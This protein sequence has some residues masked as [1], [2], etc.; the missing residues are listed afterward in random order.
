MKALILL[1]I[2]TFITACNAG[3]SPTPPDQHTE[4]IPGKAYPIK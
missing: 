2:C 1:L 4:S 3:G